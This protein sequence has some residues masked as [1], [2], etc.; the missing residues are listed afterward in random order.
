MSKDIKDYPD[1]LI[2]KNADINETVYSKKRKRY[3]KPSKNNYGYYCI[4]LSKNGKRETFLIHRLIALHFLEPSNL[5]LVDHI[6]R[7]RTDNRVVNLHWVSH[8]DN[9][10]NQGTSKNN[11]SGHKNISFQNN[12]WQFRKMING[13]ITVEYFKTFEEAIAFKIQFCIDHDEEYII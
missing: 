8:L 12:Y 13:E 9:M 4:N 5:N 11:T 6:N 3:L 7:V 1:Y 2:Y 10:N